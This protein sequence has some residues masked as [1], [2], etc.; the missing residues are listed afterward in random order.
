[1][2]DVTRA[3]RNHPRRRRL[4]VA[5]LIVGVVLV[6]AACSSKGYGT[7]ASSSTSSP[8]KATGSGGA[9]GDGSAGS[10][11]TEASGSAAS[12]DLAVAT[13][14]LGAVVVDSTGRTLYTYGKDTG[15]T[16]TCTGACAKAWPAAVANGT[17]TKST[18]I[19]ATV[20]VTTA[21]DGS[22]QLVLDGHPLYRYAAD[23][24][25]GDVNGQGVANVWYA[26][27]AGGQKAG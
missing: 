8:A 23:T 6:A 24:A 16:P 10:S 3:A 2:A 22:S 1:M 19:T 13:T 11:T 14:S 9:Y 17:P 4:N 12:T 5:A 26:V 27:T 18:D 20:T 15:T 21:A 7:S 25:P